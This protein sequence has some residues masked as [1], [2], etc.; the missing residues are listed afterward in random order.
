[1]SEQDL[2]SSRPDQTLFL[3]AVSPFVITQVDT[4]GFHVERT[5]R[6]HHSVFATLCTTWRIENSHF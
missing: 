1:M 3:S 6:D 2:P 4:L 5:D